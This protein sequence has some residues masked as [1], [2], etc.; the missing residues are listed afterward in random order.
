MLEHQRHGA[1]LWLL[2]SVLSLLGLLLV[3]ELNRSHPHHSQRRV[4]REP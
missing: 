1:G 4:Q 3:G 2:M